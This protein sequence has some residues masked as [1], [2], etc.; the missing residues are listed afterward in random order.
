[1]PNTDAEFPSAATAKYRKSCRVTRGKHQTYKRESIL[2]HY[3][4]TMLDCYWEHLDEVVGGPL[5]SLVTWA[6]LWPKLLIDYH[7]SVWSWR[8]VGLFVPLSLLFQGHHHSSLPGCTWWVRRCRLRPRLRVLPLLLY[9]Q[10]AIWLV[11]IWWF[12]LYRDQVIQLWILIKWLQ[13]A[14]FS[15]PEP[16]WTSDATFLLSWDVIVQPQLFYLLY[17]TAARE[18]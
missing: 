2:F 10:V 15:L 12:Q 9:R 13:F 1:M 17:H 3:N 4:Y 16:V 5:L 8:Y 7:W 6:S 14:L 18:N 11:E